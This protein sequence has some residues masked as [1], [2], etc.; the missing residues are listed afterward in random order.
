MPRRETWMKGFYSCYGP[1]HLFNLCVFIDSAH[2]G[3]RYSTHSNRTMRKFFL[4]ATLS[5]LSL[6]PSANAQ[7]ARVLDVTVNHEFAVG[8]NVLPAGAYRFAVEQRGALALLQIT[9]SKGGANLSVIDRLRGPDAVFREGSLVF[10]VVNGS[11]VLSEVWIPGEGGL[12]VSSVPGAHQHQVVIAMPSGENLSG[13]AVYERTCQKC[14]G[15]EGRGSEAAEKF[16]G[17]PIPRLNSKYVQSKPDAEIKEIVTQGRRGMEAVR[18]GQ[19]GVSHLLSGK[20]VDAVVGYLRALK[21]E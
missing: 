10:D 20:S 4:A 13:K 12:V 7:R 19:P 6:L 15:P 3:V 17:T 16:F 11:R 14:H 2:A 1:L 21:Q 9:G 5:A 8:R 18:I